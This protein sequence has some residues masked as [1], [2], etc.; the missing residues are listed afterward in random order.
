MNKF[1]L[2][3][4]ILVNGVAIPAWA[5]KRVSRGPASVVEG[6]VPDNGKR[7]PSS[8]RKVRPA[9]ANS[10]STA[11][12]SNAELVNRFATYKAKNNLSTYRT[13]QFFSSRLRINT[14]E[15]L[16]RYIGTR[17]AQSKNGDAVVVEAV[18][19]F[20]ESGMT[21]EQSL[22]AVSDIVGQLTETLN[23]IYT[24]ASGGKV[25]SR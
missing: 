17:F 22:A 20:K 8:E 25:A 2:S 18:N 12:M 24:R 3:V 19:A 15:I 14:T 5:G 10:S 11:R 6:T 4:I 7:A 1:L 9:A 13:A 16:K 23:S 21:Y